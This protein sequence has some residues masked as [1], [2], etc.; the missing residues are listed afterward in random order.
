MTTT[1]GLQTKYGT[2]TVDIGH[3]QG[4]PPAVVDR[5]TDLLT[6]A[7]TAD[8][9]SKPVLRRVKA[10][11]L[12]TKGAKPVRDAVLYDPDGNAV[13]FYVYEEEGRSG[14][15]TADYEYEIEV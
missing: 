1:V 8:M 10:C 2:I 5:L 3:A 6:H 14:W 12:G 13:A 4:V 11:D 9:L 15:R 7:T